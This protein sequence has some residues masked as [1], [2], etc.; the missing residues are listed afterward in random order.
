MDVLFVWLKKNAILSSYSK[1][2]KIY[3]YYKRLWYEY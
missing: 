1:N 2:I 3:S